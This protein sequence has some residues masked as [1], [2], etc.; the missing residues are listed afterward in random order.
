M[1]DMTLQNL[2]VVTGGPGAG[3]TTLIRALAQAGFAV[4]P[5]AGR[6]VIQDQQANGGRALPWIDPL[7]FAESMLACDVESYAE[8]RDAG[9]PVFFDRGIPDVIG[10][11]SLEGRPIPTTMLRAAREHR[12][13]TRVFICPPWPAIYTTDSERR[14]TLEVAERTWQ[15]MV[16]T[17]T[18]LGYTLIEVPRAPVDE[19]VRF[20]QRWMV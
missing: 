5:E 2:F 11:L 4:V 17:Y 14:Q 16:E 19:R 12:Y 3:K 15:A 10:Y 7:A 13:A 9:A 8:H 6:R 1:D 18:G 20:V